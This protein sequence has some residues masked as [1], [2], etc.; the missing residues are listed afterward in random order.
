MRA[1]SVLFV[2]ASL[3]ALST[4]AASAADQIGPTDPSP[5]GPGGRAAPQAGDGTVAE[6]VVTAARLDKAR[7]TI[8][9]GLGASKYSLPSQFVDNL[10]GGTNNQLNLVILQAPGATQDSFGQL[11]IR[12]DHANL[13]YRLNNVILPEG[14]AVFGQTLSPRLAK[15]VDLITGALPAQYGLR[16]AGIVNITTKSGFANGGEVSVYG[17]S[18]G[19]IEPSFEYGA[20]SGANSGFISGSYLQNNLGIESPDASS[21]PLHDHTRQFQLFGY[22]DHI[23]DDSSRISLIGGTSVSDFE[24]PNRSG[25]H[26]G[27]GL[28][29]NGQGDF[30]SDDL[31]ETQHEATSYAIASYLHTTDRLTTQ[32]SLFARYSTLTFRPDPLGDLL[33][34]G[35]SQYA[36]KKDLAAGLQV[37]SA[38]SLNDFHTIR[39]GIIVQGDR[40]TSD[41]TSQVLPVDPSGAQTSDVPLS[42]IDDSG[43]TSWTYSA[44]VQD[45][46]KLTDTLTLNYGLRFDQ[47]N[48]YR[49]E[50]QFSP[51]VN[52][53]WNLPTGTTFHAGYSRYFTPPPTELVAT[54]AVARFAGTTA[55][56]AGTG[57]TA[58]FAERSHYFDVGAQQKIG[59]LTVGIDSYYK[60]VH[61]L[62]DEGQF[63]APIIL[64]P[65]NYE[66]GKVYGVEFTAN[67]SRG[68]FSI[69]GSFAVSKAQGR[70]IVSSQFN[71]DPA[72]LAYIAGHF[73]PLDHDQR[74]TASAGSSYKL[75]D[76]TFSA[77]M[78][79]GS[80]LRRDGATPNGDKLPAYTQVNLSVAHNFADAP[81]GPIEVRFDVINAFDHVYEIR[82]G[83]GIGVGAPQFGPRRGFFVGL[84]KSF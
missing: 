28:T 80:G 39:G 3:L 29:V 71:F 61:D 14:L 11:H 46:W 79:Y 63:G 58:P 60:K 72:D 6:V 27:L 42:I 52:L 70:N 40:A 53:V 57:D 8:E 16:T 44:F 64:T 67:Y 84:T 19:E 20:T 9:P 32:A 23:I 54:E 45:E 56:P 7:D 35:I 30:L 1:T 26:P 34:D 36:A 83:S 62:L 81:F 38:Y 24:I 4:G 13:Q 15:N 51:R 18:H 41:T 78:I 10:P 37:E 74:Y 65:F 17:G 31:D 77:D 76:T 22:A 47:L 68:P 12:G 5:G 2:A 21:T 59:A 66:D 49:N 50:H 75:G 69:Y 55:A 33:F 25:V 73:I 43:K 82:D 48:S